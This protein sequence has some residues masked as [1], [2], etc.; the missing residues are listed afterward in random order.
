MPRKS[1]ARK[2]KAAAK[3][4]RKSLVVKKK[5]DESLTRPIVED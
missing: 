4:L 5:S 1:L 3:R 2:S